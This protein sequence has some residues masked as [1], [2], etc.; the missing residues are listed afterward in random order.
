MRIGCLAGPSLALS[1][2]IASAWGQES[3]AIISGT[4]TDPQGAAVPVAIVEVKNL[5]TNVVSK[6]MTNEQGFYTLPPINPG[7]YSVTVSAPGFKT[8][9]RSN[10]ELRVADR[11]GL[12][13]RLELG[14]S[15]ETVTVMAEVPLL[16]TQSSSQGTVLNKELVQALPTR[17]RNVFD[18]VQMTAGVT[19]RVQSTFGLRPFDN[20]ENGVR[21][22]GG[23]GS[24]N[25][26]LLD[27]APNTQRESTA[28]SNVSIVPPPEA[29]GEVKIQTNLYDAEY[30]RTGGGVISVNL[31]SGT[32]RY[33]GAAWWYVRNDALNANTFES[34]AAGGQKTSYRLHEPGI[35]FAGPVRIPKLYDGRNRSF[36]MYTLEIFRDVRPSP[37][38]MVVPTDLQKGGDFSQTYVAGTGGPTATIYD[39]LTTV[40]S[41]TSYTRTSFADNRIPVSRINP[42]A[43]NIMQVEL[44]PNLG[45]VPRGQ[46]NL[47]VTPNPDLEPYNA[48][49]LRFDQVINA[50]HRFFVNFGR[51]NRHQTNGLGLGLAAYLAS[52][53][54]EASSTYTHWRINHAATFNLTSMLSPSL[55]STARVSWNRHQFAI[56]PYSFGYDPAKLGFAPTLVAQAQ[57]RSFP[58]INIAGFSGLG[59]AGD[60]LNFSDTWAVG[61]TV[62]KIIGAHSVK[63]G[64]D[65]RLMLNNQSNPSGFATF[66]FEVNETRADP[67]VASSTSGDGLASLLL[68]YP[69]SLSSTY[70]NQAAQG[71]RY[72]AVFAQDDWRVTQNLTLNLGFRWDYESPVSDRFDRLVSGFDIS[73]ITRL[74]SANG[75]QIRGG[76][77]FADANHRLPYRRDLNNFGPRIGF[78]YKMGSKLVARGGWG[79][80]Y[81]P[82]ADVAPA[83]GFSFTT[84]PSASVANAGIVPITTP[85][86]TGTACGMLSNPF[87]D[88]IRLPPGR[89]LGLETNVGQSISYIW[90]ERTIPYLHSFSAG[91]QYELPFRSVVEVSYSGSRTRNL[92]T[93]KN[94][95]S[96]TFEQFL[97]NGA[98]LTGTTVANPFAGRL[99]GSSLNG[100]TMTLQQSLL[101]YPQFTGI[102]ETGRSIGAARYDSFLIRFEKRL[103]AGLT[104]LFTG[105]LTNCT[106]YTSYLNSGMDRIGQFITRDGGT[107]PWQYNLSSTYDLPF[108]KNSRGL[109][110]TMLGGW[111]L[112]GIVSWFP[113]GIIGAGGANSTGLDP[114]LPHPTYNRWFNTC[115]FNNN[116][117]KRQ[118]CASEGEPVAWIIQKPFTLITRPDP[119]WSSVRV[120]VPAEFNASLFKSFQI[121][122]LLR[123]EFRTEAFN[124]FNTPR[125]NGPTTSATSSQ[126]GVVTLSQANAPRSLQLSLRLSF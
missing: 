95:N 78:A 23:Q 18:L 108:F 94:F 35:H 45:V 59:R 99:P 71:Q 124:A 51:T 8:A 65:A 93:S 62:S 3:R 83:T 125:F 22:N 75:L 115:T 4:V 29:V 25:E 107:P 67:L 116:T 14:G 19:G 24:T 63:F 52:G 40:Q 86:C 56:H 12:D 43:A 72:Y 9:V 101:P 7:P 1:L 91:V 88:G 77:L 11:L 73:S 111:Q 90:P 64:G 80:A 76:L 5:E 119:E 87:P 42:I 54:P 26:V 118:S 89:S 92:P 122:E 110:R 21:I 39:P 44:Q 85:G 104:V 53:H 126:F 68:G 55:I 84:S 28:P 70:Q 38:S 102:T 36:F 2:F 117:G 123:M 13:F 103:S 41:G 15:S 57:A 120:R 79:I 27:G 98:N 16:E 31:R 61:E 58:V 82:T 49:V 74:G 109:T 50:R 114:A 30:G 121:K 97:T 66:S 20:G 96:V 10:V 112:S 33:H 17:G 113:G 6:V 106:T 81:A 46:P 34:N 48:H 69:R 47:L 37:S 100:A 32:N 105:T 60:T